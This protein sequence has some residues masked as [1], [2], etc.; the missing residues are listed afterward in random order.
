MSTGSVNM[1]EYYMQLSL[2]IFCLV[3]GGSMSFRGLLRLRG[4]GVDVMIGSVG[5]VERYDDGIGL[6]FLWMNR[7]EERVMW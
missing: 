1:L 6:Y 7:D 4:F 3:S 5:V 2:Y